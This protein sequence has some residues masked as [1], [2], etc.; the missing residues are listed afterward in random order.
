MLA[1]A[2]R[3]RRVRR[4]GALGDYV[5]SSLCTSRQFWDMYSRQRLI[6]I[7]YVCACGCGVRVCAHVRTCVEYAYLYI[8]TAWCFALLLALT[9]FAQTSTF[10]QSVAVS[11]SIHVCASCLSSM[12]TPESTQ[13]AI[14]MLH[15]Y[16]VSGEATSRRHSSEFERSMVYFH[17]C[18]RL[19]S[20]MHEW[21]HLCAHI[22]TRACMHTRVH[23][24]VHVYI[25]CV[26]IPV[27]TSRKQ[28][29]TQYIHANQQTC[30][31][32]YV[33]A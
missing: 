19:L 3:K 6:Y 31:S 33:H 24:C 16:R 9:M 18:A 15:I 22:C 4:E 20:Y 2:G 28:I 32:A 14:L 13:Y 1:G 29:Y 27:Y 5:H 30:T 12:F 26:Y 11:L 8:V 21:T 17:E 25:P 10:V 23:T 7:I